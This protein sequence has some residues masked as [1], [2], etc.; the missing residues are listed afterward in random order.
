MMTFVHRAGLGLALACTLLTDKAA[1][2]PD[3]PRCTSELIKAAEANLPEAIAFK[4]QEA[5]IVLSQ[6]YGCQMAGSEPVKVIS[7]D[8]DSIGKLKGLL[9]AGPSN[10][11]FGSAA[12]EHYWVVQP[13]DQSPLRLGGGAV[14]LPLDEVATKYGMGDEFSL[15]FEKDKDAISKGY[16]RAPIDEV[17]KTIHTEQAFEHA[18]YDLSEWPTLLFGISVSDRY[19][20][21]LESQPVS[22]E[23]WLGN[24]RHGNTVLGMSIREAALEKLRFAAEGFRDCS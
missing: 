14:F 21:R 23:V 9:Y 6:A 16:F 10:E 15:Q 3:P 8:G 12:K 5:Q 1:T 18:F 7:R 4:P 13:D 17:Y 19:N 24:V 22:A 11:A 2:Q 20:L